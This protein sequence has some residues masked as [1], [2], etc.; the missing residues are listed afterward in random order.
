[1]SVN[2]QSSFALV[3]YQIPEKHKAK[4][5]TA[6]HQRGQVKPVLQHLENSF[7]GLHKQQ[8]ITARMDVFIIV[9]VVLIVVVVAAAGYYG[10]R[11][12]KNRQ[13]RKQPD[14]P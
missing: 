4:T 2:L 11:W 10:R 6:H 5:S 1:M 8:E 12:Y 9:I 14:Y 7:P 3:G 13:A